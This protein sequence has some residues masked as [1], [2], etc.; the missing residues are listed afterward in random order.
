MQKESIFIFIKVCWTSCDACLSEY[1]GFYVIQCCDN[2]L[3]ITGKHIDSS[4][5]LKDMLIYVFYVICAKKQ[6]IYAIFV[7]Y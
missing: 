2:S 7:Q 4:V 1:K 6:T 5:H 3:V